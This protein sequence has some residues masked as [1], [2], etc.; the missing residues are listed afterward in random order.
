M[1][2]DDP[3]PLD[4]A[5]DV[6]A[7]PESSKTAQALDA[8]PDAV[9]VYLHQIG[10]LPRLSERQTIELA[11][12]IEGGRSEVRACLFQ[13]PMAIAYL[14]GL[15]E[16]L[17]EGKVASRD[18]VTLPHP[19]DVVTLEDR[20]ERFLSEEERL[21]RLARRAPG[22]GYL[23][24]LRKR[25][26]KRIAS[27]DLADKVIDGMAA[28]LEQAS[29]LV[30]D[31]ERILRRATSR[32]KL[33]AEA[34][35][36]RQ[37]IR[38]VLA[39]VGITAEELHELARKVRVAIARTNRAKHVFTEANLRLVVWIAKRYGSRGMGL[40]DLIQEGNI[41]LMRAV[42]RFDHR[43]GCKFSTYAVG[44]IKQAMARAILAQGRVVTVPSHTRE[45]LSCVRAAKRTLAATLDREPTVDEIA[46]E[47][48]VDVSRVRDLLD[49]LSN[50]L[51]LDDRV[52]ENDDRTWNDLL[53]DHRTLPPDVIAD[54]D[55]QAEHA[56]RGL[57]TLPEREA[58]IVRLRF[59]IDCPRGDQS[60]GEVADC[61]GVSR[62]RVRQ[63]EGRA[64]RRLRVGPA[65]AQA[66][67]DQATGRRSGVP[68]QP[69]DG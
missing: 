56:D 36:A 1:T 15:A 31:Q 30:R 54:V 9:G 22:R 60:L 21:A 16:R 10:K 49:A 51:S 45:I 37:S 61:F 62:E 50:H 42:E 48:K 26:A 4:A 19:D 13:L 53:E 20:V 18:V 11:R 41:G 17:R 57:A 7:T 28:K 34:R 63:I 25:I 59:G 39:T 69:S 52:R 58:A 40:L 3:D 44:W 29:V 23:N 35:A 24:G 8:D 66:E 6:E 33:E 32:K 46:T 68:R 38:E 55:L 64:L 47:A 2:S 27:L 43:I 67:A 5:G 12:E 65:T 14:E